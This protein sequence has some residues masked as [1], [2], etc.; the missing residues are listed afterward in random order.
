MEKWNIL[1]ILKLGLPGLVFLLSV[2]SFRLLSKE[3]GKARPSPSILKS[4]KSFMYINVFLAVLTLASPIIDNKLAAKTDFAS[5]ETPHSYNLEAKIGSTILETG[6]VAVCH[7]ADYVNRYL[8]IQ[9]IK[10]GRL[11]QVFS[12]SMMP[13]SEQQTEII[14][15]NEA[16]ARKLGWSTGVVSADVEVVVALPGY[17]FTIGSS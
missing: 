2:L 6:T 13:C 17:M 4:I 8:L 1:E 14:A 5:M 12:K 9:D 16:D 7:D 15:L 11:I 3:Q 10:T